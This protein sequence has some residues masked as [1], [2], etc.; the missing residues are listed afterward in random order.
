[1]TSNNYPL[2][3]FSIT[4]YKSIKS[5]NNFSMRSLNVLIGA[6]GVGKSNFVSFF[7]ML[8]ELV[9]Q[10]LKVWVQKQGGAERVLSFGIKE[11]PVLKASIKFGCNTY[12]FSLEPTAG[13]DFIFS[14]ETF[15][16]DG[17]FG[18]KET[19]TKL[20][21]HAESELKNKQSKPDKGDIFP[22]NPTIADH[23]YSAISSW[24]VLHFH[25]T[26]ETALVKRPCSA[27][28]NKHLR[29]DASNL[30]AF[31]Y[32]LQQTDNDTY[33]QIRKTVAL[34]IPFFDDF[35]LKPTKLPTEE[36]Q[37]RLLWKQKD[38]DYAF[39]PSQLSDGS[40]RFICLVTALMQPKPPSIIII[41]EPELGL[42]PY[43]IVLLGSLIRAASEKSQII[44]STQSVALLN[45][46]T[47]DD[48]IIV[49]RADRAS[50]FKR[51]D[52]NDFSTW[53][54]TYSIGELWEKNILGGRPKE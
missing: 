4:G 29:P 36:E 9:E 46:F 28:D 42:H 14:E 2:L 38:S 34:A 53:L 44:I 51:C 8:S 26:S 7:G 49:E 32:R 41:D 11:T 33:S 20:S 45:E 54:E 3:E 12:G 39:W 47:I 22:N 18:Y 5:L 35:V 27:H 17:S 48:L 40:I 16:F 10:R 30:A 24:K 25:D 50:V 52:A 15:Y 13:S 43:A 6:N 23:I 1:M 31:L 37:I 19:Q 21:G